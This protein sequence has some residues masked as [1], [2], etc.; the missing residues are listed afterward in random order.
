MD[1]AKVYVIKIL[2]VTMAN[3]VDRKKVG[4]IGNFK[5]IIYKKY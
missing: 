3:A 5:L 4:D 2:H 1:T